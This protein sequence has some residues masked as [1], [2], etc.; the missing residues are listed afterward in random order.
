MNSKFDIS[1]KAP[2][3]GASQQTIVIDS[4][5]HVNLEDRAY[6]DQSQYLEKFGEKNT[7]KYLSKEAQYISS[8]VFY[9][10]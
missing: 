10:R 8:M 5:S 3:I 1:K 7:S 2:P 4:L 9:A 6:F